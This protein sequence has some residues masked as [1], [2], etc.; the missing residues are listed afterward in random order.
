MKKFKLKFL[1]LNT[2]RCK[3]LHTDI[4]TTYGVGIESYF[5]V[6]HSVMKT[7][8]TRVN[9]AIREALFQNFHMDPRA[10]SFITL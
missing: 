3:I 9:F 4:S 7:N 2:A 1:L 5:F 6:F 10:L 8:G